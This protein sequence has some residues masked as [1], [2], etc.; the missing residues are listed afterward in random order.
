MATFARR[1]LDGETIDAETM[2][3]T[4]LA[5]LMHEFATVVDTTGAVALVEIASRAG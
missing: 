3:R 1:D 4:A 2:H 5:S